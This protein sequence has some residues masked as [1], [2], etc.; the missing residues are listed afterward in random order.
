MAEKK[1]E[2]RK[3][4]IF[5]D[6]NGNFIFRYKNGH[7]IKI[8]IDLNDIPE[9]NRIMIRNIDPKAVEKREKEGYGQMNLSDALKEINQGKKNSLSDFIKDGQL[10]DERKTV[11][12][13]II[14]AWLAGKEKGKEMEFLGGG[15]ASGKDTIFDAK[16]NLSRTDWVILDPDQFKEQLP[17]YVEMAKKSDK[18]AA[19]YHEES[20]A[21]N[22]QTGTIAYREGLKVKYNGTGDGNYY[23]LMAKIRE[24]RE[25]GYS[26]KRK[27]VT[28]DT[29]EAVKRNQQRYESAKAN[30]ENP[31][32]VDAREVRSTH[33][34]VT[35]LSIIAAPEFDSFELWDN[36]G[37]Y[38]KYKMIATAKRGEFIKPV[39]GMEADFEKYLEKGSLGKNGFVR[40]NDGSYAPTEELLENY[41]VQ[42]NALTRLRDMRSMKMGE[43][44]IGDIVTISPKWLNKGEDPDAKY[45]VLEYNEVNDRYLIRALNSKLK[46]GHTERV[47]AEMIQAAKNVPDTAR[48]TWRDRQIRPTIVSKQEF[49]Q[50]YANEYAQ[51]EGKGDYKGKEL[52]IYSNKSAIFDPYNSFIAVDEGKKQS[53]R[54]KTWEESNM[55]RSEYV[56]ELFNTAADMR[57]TEEYSSSPGDYDIE[58]R[59]IRLK[60]DLLKSEAKKYG[61]DSSTLNAIWNGTWDSTI[62]AFDMSESSAKARKPVEDDWY[63]DLGHVKTGLDEMSRTEFIDKVV[64][65]FIGDPNQD[66]LADYVA[67]YALDNNMSMESLFDD[68]E[69]EL[70]RRRYR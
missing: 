19:Y 28:V 68:I 35:D 3:E 36:N 31:R 55:L 62:P 50:N 25:A 33:Q 15:P 59:A 16:D 34:K 66:V 24:A 47:D 57:E 60:W 69:A 5:E 42:G 46:L 21:L 44:K 65:H 40:L 58:K 7:V 41:K 22:K 61:I 9:E 13:E 27:Y 20:S 49:D 26:I 17:G 63:W 45:E 56:D 38:G 67:D 23:G 10:V 11:H 53:G 64:R 37:E 54:I 1:A 6:E 29:E 30:G 52:S 51:F 43:Y 14:D 12:E 2:K 70:K 18:A 8:Y 4:R 48:F 39:S 32:L